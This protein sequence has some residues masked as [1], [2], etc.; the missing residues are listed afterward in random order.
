MWILAVPK[1][2]KST[3]NLLSILHLT[4]CDNQCEGFLEN[5]NILFHLNKLNQSLMLIYLFSYYH[6]LKIILYI[7]F[8]SYGSIYSLFSLML[9][10]LCQTFGY[11]SYLLSGITPLS[12]SLQKSLKASLCLNI[13][14]Q[15]HFVLWPLSKKPRTLV[16][17]FY[18]TTILLSVCVVKH[19]KVYF[20]IHACALNLD[21]VFL[22]YFSFL[23]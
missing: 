15:V 1:S 5:F 16:L 20:R 23:L 8:I 14:L 10:L 2:I 13:M 17:H 22:N 9:W 4:I 6:R 21:L 7:H 19:N 12:N 11:I 18:Q 3:W